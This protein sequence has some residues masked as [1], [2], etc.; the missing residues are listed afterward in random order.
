MP[1]SQSFFFLC[2]IAKSPQM[3]NCHTKNLPTGF[4]GVQVQGKSCEE[5]CIRHISD[6]NPDH[7]TVLV[8][9]SFSGWQ[10]PFHQ[11]R[12]IIFC[13]EVAADVDDDQYAEFR[14]AA[15]E[16]NRIHPSRTSIR[17]AAV[18]VHTELSPA[19]YP[20]RV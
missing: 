15:W 6:P 8:A 1:T 9:V 20:R 7:R 5:I 11:Y 18:L 2:I 13:S 3:C 17:Q 14:I 12:A 16:H 10:D 19:G 4:P